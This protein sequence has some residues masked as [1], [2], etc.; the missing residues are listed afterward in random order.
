MK[1]RIYSDL[2]NEFRRGQEW[3]PPVLLG[4]RDTVLVLAGDIDVGKHL[5]RYVDSLVDRFKAV[6]YILGNHELYGHNIDFLDKYKSTS[7][8]AYFLNN[9][10]VTIDD[11]EFL[12]TPL[13]TDMN[14]GNP[15][16]M[17]MATGMMNDFSQIRQAAEYGRL[18]SDRWIAENIKARDFLVKNLDENKK[19]VVVTHHAPDFLCAENNP[20][21]GN[22]GDYFYYNLNMQDLIVKA[23]LWIFGHSH[24]KFDKDYGDVR[25]MSNPGGYYVK[26][27]PE[28][29]V[30]NFDPACCVEV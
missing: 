10:S 1:L 24:H 28:Y 18:T 30:P 14:N 15:L 9:S 21:A 2:H 5:V 12:G 7:P 23:N 20:M 11:V 6:V 29:L 22:N 17:Q 4:E 13:W 19:Q 26:G 27:N 16:I 8:N 25:I 3:R